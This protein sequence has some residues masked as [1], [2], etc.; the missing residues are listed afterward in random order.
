MRWRGGI[1]DRLESAVWISRIYIL[2]FLVWPLVWNQWHFCTYAIVLLW[3]QSINL[4]NF[5]S[6]NIIKTLNWDCFKFLENSWEVLLELWVQ[7]WTEQYSKCNTVRC[8]LVA[9]ICIRLWQP[10]LVKYHQSSYWKSFIYSVVNDNRLRAYRCLGYI[11]DS[12]IKY[13]C[14]WRTVWSSAQE[15]C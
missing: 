1:R 8:P 7:S 15:V 12:F 10:R 4:C 6:L 13:A 14:D 2:Y 11:H 9:A 5:F 3:L